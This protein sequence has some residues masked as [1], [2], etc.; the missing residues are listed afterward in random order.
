MGESDI[1]NLSIAACQDDLRRRVESGIF[2]TLGALNLERDKTSVITAS[3]AEEQAGSSGEN[4]SNCSLL[5]LRREADVSALV[6]GAQTGCWFVPTCF[7]CGGGV[8]MVFS[9][10]FPLPQS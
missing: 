9:Q 10:S 7:D 8:E 1:F 4:G 6:P 2:S 3:P 5:T